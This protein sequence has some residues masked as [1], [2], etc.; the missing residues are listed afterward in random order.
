MKS[1][2]FAASAVDWREHLRSNT[3]RT[4]WVIGM[5]IGLYIFLGL[6]VDTYLTLQH[7]PIPLDI[8]TILKALLTLQIF[9]YA[10]ITMG[11]V[12]AIS[13]FVTYHFHDKIMLLG[14][15]SHEVTPKTAKNLEEQ[16]LYNVIE[17]M[18]IAASLK[19]MPKVY[20][21][22][23]DYMNAFA[24]GYSEKS[25]MVTITRGLLQKLNRAELQAVMA[26]E[27]SHILHQDI[28][29]TLLASVLANLML[30]VLDMLFYTALF[31]RN[32]DNNQKNS[33]ILTVIIL[34]R[35]ILPI[36]SVL[37][38]LYLSRTREYMADAGCVE[39]TRDN[40]SLIN[41]LLKIH[42]DHLDNREQYGNEYSQT[43]HEDVRREAYL[44]DPIQCGIEPAK[45]ISN[46]FS[47]HPAI[48]DRLK[49]LGY[50]IKNASK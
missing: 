1:S 6:L 35:Y 37:L 47:T 9:P 14:T 12:A 5:F 20:I 30:I 17:E 34:L 8:S 2:G 36:T 33:G 18:K 29:L 49:A 27:L 40:Q 44:Y 32:D 16:Q 31:G 41:A 7:S 25:A 26:H 50:Q 19:Y 10:T 21:I 39:L 13:I 4:R 42:N 22:E 24:S 38:L 46:L 48:E 28:K 43:A 23:A 45:S 11:A 15:D 3:R